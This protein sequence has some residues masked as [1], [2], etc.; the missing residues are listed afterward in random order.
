MAAFRLLWVSPG[1][2]SSQI[3]TAEKL[4]VLRSPRQEYLGTLLK[5]VFF[6]AETQSPNPA[7]LTRGDNTQ[8]V[9]FRTDIL[10][11]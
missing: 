3:L 8:R 9:P 10:G 5:V 2:F 1:T 11:A 7:G 4:E 6:A